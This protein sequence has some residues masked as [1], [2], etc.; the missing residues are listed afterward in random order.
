MG[1]A[2]DCHPGLVIA[3]LLLEDEVTDFIF[4]QDEAPP[5]WP[6]SVRGYLNDK[7]PQWRIGLRA[8][9]VLTLNHCPSRSP[10]LTPCDFFLCSCIKVSVFPPLRT[11][12]S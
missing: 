1:G 4:Q 10:D 2:E 12:A 5:H 8:D 9:D 6:L 7:F 3:A 11:T